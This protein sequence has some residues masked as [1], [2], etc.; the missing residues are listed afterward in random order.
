MEACWAHN[1]EVGRSKL[2]AAMFLF[3]TCKHCFEILCNGE[4]N[5]F[6]ITLKRST[7][8][9]ND[10][11]YVRSVAFLILMVYNIKNKK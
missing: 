2:L 11:E 10:G 3:F 9:A 1:S 6:V 4:R 7:G 8:D 5:S